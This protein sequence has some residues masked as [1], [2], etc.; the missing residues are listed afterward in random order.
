[1]KIK[2]QDNIS[3]RELL[4]RANVERLSE[5]VRRRRWRFSGHILRQ[6]PDNHCVTALTESS[7]VSGNAIWFN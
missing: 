6:Q 7:K 1:M 3:N 2:W 4:K 5:Q